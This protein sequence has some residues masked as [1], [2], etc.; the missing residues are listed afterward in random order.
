MVA[1]QHLNNDGK[2]IYGAYVVG[3][4]WFFLALHG[5]EY[6]L[7]LAHDATKEHDLLHIFRMLKYIK[8]IVE[9]EL[10]HEHS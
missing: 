10:A 8:Q 9:Q 5:H 6:A 3:R 2:P 7:S 1:A 4:H